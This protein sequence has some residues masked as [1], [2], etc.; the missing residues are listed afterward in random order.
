MSKETMR[1]RARVALLAAVFAAFSVLIPVFACS[2]IKNMKQP[3][4]DRRETKYYS[5]SN[6]V[7][8]YDVSSSKLVEMDLEG[9]V[10]GVLAGEMPASYEMEALKAQA[11]AARTF[12]IEKM[13]NGGCGKASGAQVCTDSTHCQA[14]CSEQERMKK[15]GASF[16]ENEK[17]LRQAVEATRGEI[18]LYHDEPI[19][20][21]FH[22]SSGGITEDVENVFSQALPYLRSV[23]SEGEENEPRFSSNRIISKDEFKSTVKSRSGSARFE[24][25]NAAAWIGDIVRFPSGRVKSIIIGGTSFTGRE[26]RGMFEL[27]STNFDIA[28]KN[29][30]VIFSTRG[31]GH[32]VGMSQTGADAMAKRGASYREILMHYY[33]G[34]EIAAIEE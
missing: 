23:K 15:W 27:D 34:I 26:V 28:F 18:M 17:K 24:A 6:T 21:L 31:Y 29:G 11:V 10:L 16:D 2:Y 14:Y 30:D 32:G 33:T 19:L 22:S 25:G 9:Y 7:R 8:V 3:D 5:H 4:G 13:E 20:A 12:T 1:N